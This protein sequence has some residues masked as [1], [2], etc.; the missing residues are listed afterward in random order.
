MVEGEI[1]ERSGRGQEQSIPVR[2]VEEPCR[3]YCWTLRARFGAILAIGL[4]AG[5]GLKL[6]AQAA[7]SGAQLDLQYHLR[8][9]RP[10]THIMDVEIDAGNV[11]ASS[12]DFVLPAWAPGRYAI[13]NFAKNVQQ[14]HAVG[15]QGQPLPWTSV[16]KQTWRVDTRGAGGSVRATYRV[17]GNDLTGSFS[18]FDATHANINGASVYMYIAGHKPD[19]ISLTV[20]TPPD[21]AKDGKTVDGFTLSTAQHDFHVLNYDRLID[22]PMEISP[23]CQVAT[24]QDHGRT[25]RVAVHAHNG[26]DKDVS[27]PMAKLVDGIKRVVNAEMG[28]MP[29]PDFDDYTFI[30]HFSPY[31]D[32]GDGM[33]HLNS[34]EIMVRDELSDSS[35]DQAIEIA[36]HEFFHVWNVK[37]LRPQGLGPFNYTREVYTPSLWFAEG[38]TSYFGYWNLLR[39]GI[40][41]RNDFLK[42]LSNEVRHF[43]EEPGRG[44]MSA[45]SSSFHAWFYDRAPQMQE[46]NFANST[47]SYYNKGALL[48]MLLDLAIRSHTGGAKSLVDV[49]HNLYH[50][51]YEA[52]PA[53]YYGPGHGYTED[54][55]VNAL[56]EVSGTDFSQFFQDYIRGTQPLPYDDILKLAGLKLV[57]TIEPGAPP[58]LGVQIESN[59]LGEKITSVVPG[60]S[61]D[62]AGLSRD[63]ELIAVD[64]LSLATTS[65]GDR[66]KMYP[67]G[68]AVPF[69]V[70]RYGRRLRISAKLDPPAAWKYSIQPLPGA[71]PDQIRI[72]EAWLHGDLAGGA[73]EP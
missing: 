6:R 36:A 7:H 12:L 50:E 38:V 19:A 39:S 20:E 34:T 31:I 51:C 4:Y 40:W 55:I 25:F 23:R 60:G 43:Q 2:R 33:E 32:L 61:A 10:T 35:V 26:G 69:T 16:D 37:R 9:R 17:Y 63:D 54:D 73:T 8:L 71:T 21:W 15:A 59:D 30:F 68:A 70:Q 41:D 47:I 52:P 56:N 28:M 49:M 18:Q 11:S 3:L 1:K 58:S 65:L 46:T 57:R 72:G 27:Q 64:E 29:T 22:T 48:G 24:F 66:L 13:Y 44:M 14:F 62:R 67:P 53:N 42:A 45:E 5:A